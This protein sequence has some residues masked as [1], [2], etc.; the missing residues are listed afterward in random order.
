MFIYSFYHYNFLIQ[1]PLSLRKER[2]GFSGQMIRSLLLLTILF[3][4]LFGCSHPKENRDVLFQTSTINAL[5]EGVYDGN[6]TFKE[7]KEHGDFGIGTFNGLDGEMIG[8]ENKFYQI[9]ADGKVYPVDDGMKT[10]FAMVT[11]FEP[12][13]T[14]LLD[15]SMD[16]KQMEQYVDNLLLTQNIFYAVRIEGDFTYIKTRS[17]PR[18]N[19][20]YL[21]LVEVVKSQPTFEFHNVKGTIGGFWLPDYMK[22]INVPGYHFHFITDDRKAG[23]HLLDC[24]VKDVRIEIDYTPSFYI[25]LPGQ[26]EFYKTDL[27]RG[28]QKELERV[29]K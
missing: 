29:E 7:L 24:K 8:L 15:K 12:D 22:G 25:I 27:T 4:S 5:L 6:T 21:R 13:K 20:P 1:F 3:V 18:Q 28:K 26:G 17:V 11:F 9:K 2:K 23:G 10:S 16:C 19:K 14:V